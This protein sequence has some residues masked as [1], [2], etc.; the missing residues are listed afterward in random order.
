M[1]KIGF[2]LGGDNGWKKLDFCQTIIGDKKY[3]VLYEKNVFDENF[4]ICLWSV[5][6]NG[7]KK[8]VFAKKV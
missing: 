6:H 7:C 1:K 4:G 2:I 5:V 8:I 3:W